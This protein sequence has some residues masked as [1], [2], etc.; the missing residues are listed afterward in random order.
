MFSMVIPPPNVTGNLH[1]GHALTVA[2]EDALVRR[3]RQLGFDTVWVPGTVRPMRSSLVCADLLQALTTQESQ[4]KWCVVSH[5]ASVLG[6]FGEGWT[7]F[8]LL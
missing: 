2:V 5:F 8:V 6:S 4:R 7:G 3:H 1:I